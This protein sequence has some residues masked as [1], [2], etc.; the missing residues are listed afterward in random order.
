MP[1]PLAHLAALLARPD[2]AAR[3][4]YL[5]EA[6]RERGLEPQ[7]DAVGNV[8]AGQGPV[9]LA[10][11][12]D[13]VLPP[14]LLARDEA[15]WRGPG[16]GDNLS[17]VAVLLERATPDPRFTFAF[18]V[19][20][21]GLGNLKGARHL[22]ASRR[23][24]R[25]V[26]VDGYLGDLVTRAVGSLRLEAVFTGPGGHAWAKRRTPSPARA[27]G[28]ALELLFGL[29]LGDEESLNV[30]RVFGGEAINAV[31]RRMGLWLEV[32]SADP[33][34]LVALAEEV[35]QR[36]MHAGAEAGVGLELRPLGRRPAGAS[37]DP[38]L[39]AA[40]R[41]ALLEVGVEPRLAAASTDAAAAVEAGVPAI[42]FG[43]YR[44]GGAHTEEEWVEVASL[45]TGVRAL[46]GLMERLS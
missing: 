10:A 7:V 8:V 18:T 12:Y 32:R 14:A 37:A 27:L 34:R 41:A 13:T 24:S 6:L 33:A 20:E 46:A 22:V 43:V 31:P 40:A 39:V 28:R 5:V 1:G 11:H 9:A 29:E 4:D 35:R 42:G 26:A 2:E 21:E 38:G 30:G 23:F 36:L 44:G 45:D 19:G 16:V 25:F 17:G 3:R 15:A